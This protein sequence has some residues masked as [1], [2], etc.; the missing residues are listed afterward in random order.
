METYL[1]IIN[2][3]SSIFI[4]ESPLYTVFV[5]LLIYLLYRNNKMERKYDIMVDNKDVEI[6]EL[7]DS[8]RDNYKDNMIILNEVNRTLDL[9]I[10]NQ[11]NAN[12]SLVKEIVELKKHLNDKK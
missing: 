2:D 7:N 11:K 9:F 6:K 1:F 3:W 10:N 12:D 8:I 5:V 4:I